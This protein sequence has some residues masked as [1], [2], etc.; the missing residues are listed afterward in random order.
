MRRMDAACAWR[1]MHL[2]Y[3]NVGHPRI[4]LLIL[5]AGLALGAG[6]NNSLFDASGVPPAGALVCTLPATHACEPIRAC[7]ADSDADHCEADCHACTTTVQDAKAIC[8]ANRCGYECPAG[9][10]QCATGCC[11]AAVLAAG[12]DHACAITAGTGELLCWGANNDGQLGI[13]DASGA[14]Q[15]TP[16][17]ISLPGRVISVGAGGAHSC[18]VI[19]G[20]AVW[21][22][23][24][25]SSF[26]SGVSYSYAPVEVGL[27][28]ASAVVAG[29][30]HTCA[31]TAGGAVQCR[32]AWNPAGDVVGIPVSG[33]AKALA[34]GDDFTCA[35]VATPSTPDS[36]SV[37][38]WGAN[39]HEQLGVSGITVA[40]PTTVALL[41]P[42]TAIGLGVDHGCASTAAGPLRC[43]SAKRVGTSSD[44]A[45]YRPDGVNYAASAIAGGEAHTCVVRS[46]SIEGVEC[47]GNTGDSPIIGGRAAVFGAPVHVPLAAPVAA[48]AA[49]SFHTCAIDGTGRVACWGQGGRGQLG[50]GR[51]LDSA[52]PVP[53][54]S[55]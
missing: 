36:G 20:G 5:A 3:V 33:G 19:E 1:R 31:I 41:G 55:H 26:L 11:P 7:M 43:W 10:L 4:E 18:A 39:D 17:K 34:A 27:V 28:G 42:V 50:D 44:P 53:V 48:L 13:A 2:G 30:G 38:C 8:L 32:G 21:C 47:W 16:V 9:L 40:Q 23:G 12:G 6:C 25:M 22:W 51:K 15:P 14:D 49:G 37:R 35:I 45:P 24:R 54:V 46:D 29:G 52:A